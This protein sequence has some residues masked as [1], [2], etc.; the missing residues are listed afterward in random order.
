MTAHDLLDEETFDISLVEGWSD[1]TRNALTSLQRIWE[2]DIAKLLH[3]AAKLPEQ[4]IIRHFWQ[5]VDITQPF[6]PDHHLIFGTDVRENR[7]TD[8]TGK[9]TRITPDLAV[10]SAQTNSDGL[11]AIEI[12]V[13]LKGNAA[14]NY[15]NCPKG[16]HSGY[17]N[18][19]VCYAN[20]C[21]L[22]T[23]LSTASD[24][25]YVWLAPEADR[26]C[27]LR[28]GLVDDDVLLHS[29]GA[30]RAALARQEEAWL[31]LWHFVSLE[32]L[33]AELG[34]YPAIVT[35]IEAWLVQLRE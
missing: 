32:E 15:I 27:P 33:C 35:P 3:A 34:D 21:W 7:Y 13:E 1:R 25:K 14:V 6:T 28:H 16:V 30:D 20:G 22:N 12:G 23:D 24:V 17:S 31:G 18:Q 10:V 8:D 2:V 29:W 19:P 26:G 9:K 5:A 4:K 11:R